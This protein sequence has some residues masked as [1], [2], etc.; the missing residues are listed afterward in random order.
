[1]NNAAHH[2]PRQPFRQRTDRA[3]VEPHRALIEA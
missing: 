3:P 2:A 1:M